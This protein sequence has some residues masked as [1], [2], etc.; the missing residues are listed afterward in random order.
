MRPALCDGHRHSC[1]GPSRR[2]AALDDDRHL[3]VQGNAATA[4]KLI[5]ND[6]GTTNFV[7][8]KAPDNLGG[9][10]TWT[11]PATDGTNGKLLMASGGGILTWASGLSPTGPAGGDLF[12]TYANPA[13]AAGAV[14]G[15]KIAAATITD[16]NV[17]VSGITTAGKVSGS[18]VTSGTI[19]GTTAVT[20]PAR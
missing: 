13:V 1:R 7:A 15:T 12:G 5:F 18:A 3:T 4:D 8:L 19:A 16:A 20:P 17:A 2:A 11:L 10:V 9:S 14:T 6:K